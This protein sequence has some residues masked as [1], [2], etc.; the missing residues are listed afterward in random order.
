MLRMFRVQASASDT[1]ARRSKRKGQKD[2][3]VL[4][5]L[6][7]AREVQAGHVIS[8]HIHYTMDSRDWG[9]A[10]DFPKLDLRSLAAQCLH[11][12]VLL[13]KGASPW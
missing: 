10:T 11:K 3:V 7:A 8:Y 12:C 13:G 1:D 5:F 9:L 2:L 6:P 4:H